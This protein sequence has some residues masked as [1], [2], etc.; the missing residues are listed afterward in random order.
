MSDATGILPGGNV[1]CRISFTQCAF[2][3]KPIFL[4][5]ND[6]IR[7]EQP[8]NLDWHANCCLGLEW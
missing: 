8:L 3:S 5:I 4:G 6:L 2:T 7:S 1:T